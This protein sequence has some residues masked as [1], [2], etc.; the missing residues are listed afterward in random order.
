[1]HRASYRKLHD[2]GR[3]EQRALA[4][5][6]LLRD[7]RLCPRACGVNRLEGELGFC[8]TGRLARAASFGPHFGEE[9]PLVGSHGS[10]TIFFS[11][12]NLL[13]SFCQNYDISHLRD[14]VEVDAGKIAGMMLHLARRGCHNINFV[15]PSHVVPQILEAVVLA[16]GAGLDLPLVYNSGGY[17]TVETLRLLEDVFD[18]YMPD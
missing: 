6:R 8:R 12:C 17:D 18:I 5:V 13:C 1:M 11:S 10:G 4:A 15:T 9:A 14:G 2:G 3:L 7:C 16:A